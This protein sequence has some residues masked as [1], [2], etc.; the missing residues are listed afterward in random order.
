MMNDHVKEKAGMELAASSVASTREGM[1]I[2]MQALQLT[3]F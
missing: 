1:H 2:G 3:R